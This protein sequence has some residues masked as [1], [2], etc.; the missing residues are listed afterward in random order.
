[1]DVGT[2]LVA[3]GSSTLIATAASAVV[4]WKIASSQQEVER[5]KLS[6]EREKY[7]HEKRAR[8]RDDARS[9]CQQ[10][11]DELTFMAASMQLLNDN[12]RFWEDRKD[13]EQTR[14]QAKQV[15]DDVNTVNA[16]MPGLLSDL[17]GAP[18][19]VLPD[20]AWRE[21]QRSLL[22]AQQTY[23]HIVL[24]AL[25]PGKFPKEAWG[26]WLLVYGKANMT[27]RRLMAEIG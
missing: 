15:Y 4:S 24:E 23:G 14:E 12:W 22:A 13:D 27:A 17:I 21:L 2:V 3:V 25:N 1:M 11:I 20:E 26:A 5:E 18:H 9:L 10:V 7:E 6:H 19:D 8:K 16:H